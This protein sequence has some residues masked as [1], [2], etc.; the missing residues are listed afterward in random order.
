M[1][2]YHPIPRG[3]IRIC[4]PDT[5]QQ[6][7]Y[8]CGASCLQSICKYYG[9]GPD[10]EWEFVDALGMDYRIGSHPFQIIRAANRY[11]LRCRQYWP[12]TVED[13]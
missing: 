8:S 11:G 9:V 6:E 5:T 2:T 1:P 4:L 10:D 3:A 7:D 13:I 12:M